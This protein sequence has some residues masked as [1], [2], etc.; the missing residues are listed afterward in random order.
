MNIGFFPGGLSTGSNW[1]NDG[2]FRQSSLRLLSYWIAGCFMRRR[3]QG[4]TTFGRRQGLPYRRDRGCIVPVLRNT[5]R[6][7]G[8][9]RMDAAKNPTSVRSCRHRR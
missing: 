7:T 4:Q 6:D 9:S 5:I 2:L 8:R 1:E 3:R